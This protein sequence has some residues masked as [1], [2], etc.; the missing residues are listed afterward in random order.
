MPEPR[1]YLAVEE[2]LNNNCEFD[3][4]QPS[5]NSYSKEN[6]SRICHIV[7]ND[8][9]SPYNKNIVLFIYSIRNQNGKWKI[10]SEGARRTDPGSTV[11]L[12]N[13]AIELA[14][15]NNWK[16]IAIA[17]ADAP[18]DDLINKY[19]VS[20][21]S[22]TYGDETVY[23]LT[24]ILL[25][26][27]NA[28]EPNFYRYNITTTRGH[29]ILSLIKKEYLLSYLS[30]YDNRS[31]DTAYDLRNTD[32]N[33]IHNSNNK[34]ANTLLY[35]VPG[36][37]KSYTIKTDYCDDEDRME[38]I[39][40][41]PD[42][43]Y[44]DF[45]GQILPKVDNN[46]DVSYEFT[47]GPFTRI[48][49]KALQEDRSEIEHFLIIEEINRGNAP[50][51]FGEIFQLL[52]RDEN[53]F[54][55]YGI[56]NADIAKEIYGDEKQLIKIPGNL[57]IL[58]TMNTADQNVF[59]LDTAFKRRWRMK[60]IENN[61]EICDYKNKTIAGTNVS[62]KTFMTTINEKIVESVTDN[63]GSEDKRLGAFFVEENE[64]DDIDLF[65]EKVLMYLWNDAFKYNR[66]DVFKE[67]Y[68]TLEELIAGF[69]KENIGIF[70]NNLFNMNNPNRAEEIEE[71]AEE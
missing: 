62:W 40:F 6:K 34:A 69:K 37:G 31:Y 42:Y 3:Y 32:N 36:C 38:R 43:T 9:D 46:G 58:A 55:E 39:V 27:K 19:F 44:S 14:K 7:L 4:Y 47:P 28:N 16:Y 68:S 17:A 49:K 10:H 24:D 70:N 51:I 13:S 57:S 20:V 54:S 15:S 59:T 65:S 50:A 1:F 29:Y 53:G 11:P 8:A 71:A 23:D 66:N 22:Y 21:E 33:R 56:N 64:L 67:E 12:R 52:D 25:D 5:T 2:I 30:F 18:N 26:L 63:I 45:V 41:H 61:I 35:G 60:S 48:M